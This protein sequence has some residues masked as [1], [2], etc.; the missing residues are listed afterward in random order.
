MNI[1]EESQIHIV[2]S[3]KISNPPKI[4]NPD[5][6]GQRFQNTKDADNRIFERNK[7]LI[8]TKNV[9][10]QPRNT[11]A[12]MN[13]K[14][15]D[16]GKSKRLFDIGEGRILFV[17][18]KG[19]YFSCKIGY[20]TCIKREREKQIKKTERVYSELQEEPTERLKE[21]FGRYDIEKYVELFG[22]PEEA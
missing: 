11:K 5:Q 3:K 7:M 21:I 14:M 1:T 17:T 19:N 12:I 4:K 16:T 18:P 22:E 15:Y 2:L 9:S 20:D 6:I 13:G 10:E 8:H